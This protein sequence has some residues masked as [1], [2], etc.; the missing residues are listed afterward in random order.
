MNTKTFQNND[1]TI[2]FKCKYY[3]IKGNIGNHSGF[4][5]TWSFISGFQTKKEANKSYKSIMNNDDDIKSGLTPLLIVSID[6]LIEI[7]LSS[8]RL[9]LENFADLQYYKH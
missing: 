4:N 1:V 3:I 6:E 5:R 7:Y 8:E 2:I 9:I